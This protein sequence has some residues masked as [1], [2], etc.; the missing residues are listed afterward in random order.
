MK[1]ILLIATGAPFYGRM[2]YN[3]AVTIKAVE[4]IPITVLHNG[5]GLSHLSTKQRS[6]FDNIVDIPVDS[7]AAKLCL[8]DYSPY[9]KTLYLDADMAWMPT[10]Y[11]SDLFDSLNADFTG[12]TEGYYDY[13]TGEDKGSNMY[14]YWCNPLEAKEKYKLSGKYYQWRSEVIF[15]KKSPTAKKLFEEAKKIYAKP[16]VE[17]KKFAGHIPDELAINIAACK[18]GV[19]PHQF[20][21]TPAYW[22]RLHGEG[23]S[24]P[25]IAQNNYLMSVGGNY[26]S[27]VMKDCYNRVCKAAH[28]KLGLQYLFTLQS[29][30]AVLTERLK[31]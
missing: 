14:H 4:D 24:L 23:K 12:I 25:E 5:Y 8:Y 10:R 29:K 1:G 30:K 18:L 17:G 28:N 21:W 11:P 3:L 16:K 19:E 31:M 13:E 22:H 6:I 9:D 7:F 2:A 20:K 26:A 27:G 15:F